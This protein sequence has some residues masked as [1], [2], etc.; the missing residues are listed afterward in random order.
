MADDTFIHFTLA[1]NIS[2]DY[3]S[4]ALGDDVNEFESSYILATIVIMFGVFIHISNIFIILTVFN[5]KSASNPDALILSLS[6]VDYAMTIT[7]F[8]VA[9]YHFW[10]GHEIP[11]WACTMCAFLVT[12]N[13]VFSTTVVSLMTIDRLLAIKK[14]IIYKLYLTTVNTIKILIVVLLVS[15]G[16]AAISL[17]DLIHLQYDGNDCLFEAK[18]WY[19]ILILSLIYPQIPVVV[20]TY[21]EFVHALKMFEPRQHQTTTYNANNVEK[22]KPNWFRR[23]K[24]KPKSDQKS[25]SGNHSV[26]FK[27][28]IRMSRTVAAIV[29]LYYIPCLIWTTSVLT[30]WILGR[31]LSMFSH[32]SLSLIMIDS[33]FNIVVYAVMC[34]HYRRSFHRIV[35]LPLR[36]CGMNCS[37]ELPLGLTKSE[38]RHIS[39]RMDLR[40]A[41]SPGITKR[42]RTHHTPGRDRS[43]EDMVPIDN[44]AFSNSGNASEDVISESSLRKSRIEETSADYIESNSVVQTSEVVIQLKDENVKTSGPQNG[45]VEN[46]FF[47]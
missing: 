29:I 12:V 43:V 32:I 19:T 10:T 26:S 34:L 15:I 46:V 9:A 3:S 5:L 40:E 28:C 16:T 7:V 39:N 41:Q 14:P 38:V 47:P 23:P 31:H 45:E 30:D 37:N 8:P 22:E 25:G 24:T 18:S 11:S 42:G 36:M 35:C 33:S 4:M 27:R 1:P 6:V 20:Y 21:S 13:I 17:T 2:A 44:P